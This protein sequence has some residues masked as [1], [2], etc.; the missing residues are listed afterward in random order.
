MKK[1][2]FLLISIL[3]VSCSQSDDIIEKDILIRV[4]NSSQFEFNNV[5]VNTSGSEQN[6]GDIDINQNSDYKS[7]DFAYRYAF[8]ELKIDGNTFTIQPIDYVGET[9][10]DNG[11]YTYEVNAANNGSQYSRLTLALIKD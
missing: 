5:L 9:K 3:I 1:V 7:F 4:K 2:Y 8:I 6:F 11:K 10:L